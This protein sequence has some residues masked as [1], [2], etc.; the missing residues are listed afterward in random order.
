LSVAR[1]LFVCTGN[2]CR[3]PAAALFLRRQLGEMGTTSVTVSSAGTLEAE[4]GPPP[5]LVE[6]GYRF[7]ID[8]GDHVARKVDPGMIEE[9]DLVVGVAREHVREVV[10][11]VPESFPRSFTLREIARRGL[12]VG[13]RASTEDLASWLARLCEGRQR[14][15]LVGSSPVDDIADPMGGTAA[16]YRQMLTEVSA[17]TLTLRQLAWAEPETPLL[18]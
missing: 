16:D 1:V 9:A 13:S 4:V 12:D 15:D 3:S 18:D 11:A 6:E 14:P 5:L 8:L 17:L 7:G 2:L 10:L